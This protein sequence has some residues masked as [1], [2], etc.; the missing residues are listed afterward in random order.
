MAFFKDIGYLCKE[1]KTIDELHRPKVSYNEIMV[2]CNKKEVGINEYY[3]AQSVGFK[4]E[5]KIEVRYIDDLNEQGITHFRFNGKLY[6]ILRAKSK[7]DS[8]EIVLS[9]IIINNE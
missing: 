9:S 1:V 2:Y 5:I 6:K 8:T 3:Q 7:E 4:P